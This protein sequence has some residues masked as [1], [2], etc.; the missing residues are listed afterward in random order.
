MEEPPELLL[1]DESLEAGFDSDL[2]S[3]LDSNELLDDEP[4]AAGLLP[5]DFA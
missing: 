1:E 5:P 3:E 4:D 2:D